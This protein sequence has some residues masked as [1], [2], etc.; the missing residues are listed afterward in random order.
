KRKLLSRR[1][2]A[3]SRSTKPT[4]GAPT[5]R[6]AATNA[7]GRTALASEVEAGDGSQGQRRAV[8]RAFDAERVGLHL[9]RVVFR[10]RLDALDVRGRN[11]GTRQPQQLAAQVRAERENGRNEHVEPDACPPVK[12]PDADGVRGAAHRAGEAAERRVAESEIDVRFHAAEW[13]VEA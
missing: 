9:L 6:S 11:P 1:P 2:A 5:T 8:A 10:I 13:D 3:R 7:S 4:M 12:A